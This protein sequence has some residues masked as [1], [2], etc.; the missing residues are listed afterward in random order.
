MTAGI[1][2][3]KAKEDQVALFQGFVLDSASDSAYHTGTFMAQDSRIVTDG[4]GT[5]LNNNV[6]WLSLLAMMN[7]VYDAG[8]VYSA[9]TVRTTYRMA[10]TGILHLNQNFIASNFIENH[11]LKNE[12][13]IR[14][15]DYECLRRNLLFRNH[16]GGLNGF[17]CH[18]CGMNRSSSRNTLDERSKA[19]KYE[20]V[21]GWNPSLYGNKFIPQVHL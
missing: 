4:D 17:V 3:R 2:G 12:R 13:S 6:L 10:Q 18:K 5:F 9:M 7:R 8:G 19:R 1:T 14:S 16:G 21:R 20:E 15:I 11:I